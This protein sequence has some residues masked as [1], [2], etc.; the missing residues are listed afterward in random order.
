MKKTR[1]NKILM[2]LMCFSAYCFTVSA[3]ESISFV[4]KGGIY[5]N[6]FSIGIDDG[7]QFTIDWGDGSPIDTMSSF[8]NSTNHFYS[9]SNYFTVTITGTSPG[10]T[11][12]SLDLLSE[13]A[14]AL[15]FKKQRAQIYGC[16][17]EGWRFASC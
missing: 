7:K 1:K 11:F 10:C 3:N 16:V 12:L 15:I 17:F 6:S 4:W 13:N 2:M 8:G 14:N 9:N 5:N